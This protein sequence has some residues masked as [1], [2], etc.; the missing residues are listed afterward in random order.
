[1]GKLAD[2]CK[3]SWRRLNDHEQIHG[4][5]EGVRSVEGPPKTPLTPHSWLTAIYPRPQYVEISIAKSAGFLTKDAEATTTLFVRL[6][7]AIGTT[8]PP[9]SP[10]TIL[11][12]L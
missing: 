11:I 3:K 7:L 9:L 2:K 5:I 12:G 1:M 6:Q 10:P 8:V 4:L